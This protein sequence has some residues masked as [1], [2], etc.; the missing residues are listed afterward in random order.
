MV[1]SIHLL[2]SPHLGIEMHLDHVKED[3]LVL[4]TPIVKPLDIHQSQN[5]DPSLDI[6]QDQTLT[7][8]H[9]E[10]AT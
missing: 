6:M 7:I 9:L 1:L 10:T 5:P 8:D 3:L 2:V 4:F